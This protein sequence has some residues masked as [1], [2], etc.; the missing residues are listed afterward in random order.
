MD[1][2]SSVF[3][4]VDLTSDNTT[5]EPVVECKAVL[6]LRY[7]QQPINSRAIVPVDIITEDRVQAC[8]KI[9]QRGPVDFNVTVISCWAFYTLQ[10]RGKRLSSNYVTCW[11]GDSIEAPGDCVS[12]PNLADDWIIQS[13]HQ[14]LSS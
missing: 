4:L 10:R 2:L 3:E 9:D 1:V 13:K 7:K 6:H 12:G 8:V 14:W 5:W 11:I